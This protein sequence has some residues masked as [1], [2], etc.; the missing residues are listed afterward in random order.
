M[1]FLIIFIFRYTFISLFTSCARIY[2]P[3]FRENK[4]KTIVFSNSEWQCEKAMTVLLTRFTLAFRGNQLPNWKDS[5]ILVL[6]KRWRTKSSL[7]TTSK[8]YASTCNEPGRATKNLEEM[9]TGMDTAWR[10]A[11]LRRQKEVLLQLESI[12]WLIEDQAFSLSS[13]LAPTPR[14]SLPPL[15]SAS[16]LSCVSPV[17]LTNGRKGGGEGMGNEQNHTTSRK[18]G[19][20]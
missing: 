6:T 4:P 1:N 19:P 5:S 17:E 20:L 12:D 10:V 8:W 18:P 13:D 16:C 15:P 3:S 14:P 9:P 7:F 2:R 11:D